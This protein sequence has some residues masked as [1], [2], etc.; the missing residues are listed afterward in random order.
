MNRQTRIYLAFWRKA[1]HEGELRLPMPSKGHA[2]SIRQALYRAI[3][4]FR[5]EDAEEPSELTK[6]ANT[7]TVGFSGNDLIIRRKITSEYAETLFSELELDESLLQ[8]DD[9]RQAVEKLKAALE[10]PQEPS[11]SSNPFFSRD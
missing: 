8:T 4:P 5:D 9:E 10:K 6:I 2:V 7:M 1:F 11:K 3:R